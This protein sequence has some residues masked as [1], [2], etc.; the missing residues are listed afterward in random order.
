VGL[1]QEECGAGFRSPLGTVRD[2]E[3]G[4]TEPDQAARLPDRDRSQPQGGDRGLERRALT[5]AARVEVFPS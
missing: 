5:R 3:Q 4:K 2:W 1:G